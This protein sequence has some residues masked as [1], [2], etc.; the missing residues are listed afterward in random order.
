MAAERQARPL[1]WYDVTLE[2]AEIGHEQTV[3]VL[4]ADEWMA[5]SEATFAY[6]APLRGQRVDYDVREV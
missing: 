3:I 6:G 5:R 4:A 1:K 2:V